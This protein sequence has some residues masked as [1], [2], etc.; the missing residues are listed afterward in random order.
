MSFLDQ[1]G[2]LILTHNEAPNI[3]RTLNALMW[4]QRIVVVDS[5]STDETLEIIRRY[6]QAEI[7]HRPFDSFAGQ[8]NFGL[9]Q[10]SNDWVLSLDA[11][12][13]L[14]QELITEFHH[15][16]P[17]QYT[18]GFRAS[19]VYRI[20]GRPLRGNIYPPRTVLYRKQF[21]KYCDQGHGHRVAIEGS[22][23]R[24]KGVIYHDDRKLLSSWLTAQQKYAKLEAEHLFA[25]SRA[26]LRRTD[27]IRL[28]GWPAPPLVFL[29]T[30]L[31]R[32]CIFDGWPGWLYVLQRTI[33]ETMIAIEIVDRRLRSRTASEKS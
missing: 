18:A 20:Y 14:S 19:F 15:L 26:S 11:D 17:G 24:L 10:I 1:V 21:A 22:V 16:S 8:C 30:L 3:G 28:M 13:E 2:V 5:G 23:E 4:A 9:T 32:G 7:L 25:A 6:P 12:Y 29:F 31:I 27:R 33:A